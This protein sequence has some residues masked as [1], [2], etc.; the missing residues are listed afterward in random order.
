MTHPGF[1]LTADERADLEGL[2]LRGTPAHLREKAAALLH[3]ADGLS[4]S[5][6]ARTSGLRPR[7]RKTVSAWRARYQAEG[8]AG[9]A[10]RPGRGRKPAFSPSDRP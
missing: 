9:L 6:V 4:A 2:V 1:P 10:V 7:N 8:L 5:A 3:L